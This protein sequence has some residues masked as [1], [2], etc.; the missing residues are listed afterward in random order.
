MLEDKE[1]MSKIVDEIK[2]NNPV[3]FSLI[4]TVSGS[5]RSDGYITGYIV[6]TTQFYSLVS[7]QSEADM[8]NKVI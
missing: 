2:I 5:G 3:L 7:R 8:L 6:G 4:E 1:F